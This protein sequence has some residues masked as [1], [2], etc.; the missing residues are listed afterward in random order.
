MANQ[1]LVYLTDSDAEKFILFQKYYDKFLMFLK[2]YDKFVLLLEKK[3]FEQIAAVI[4]VHF[5][6]QGEIV[7]INRSDL[8][9]QKGVNFINTN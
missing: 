5:D 3:F 1:T 7:N 9:Y 2:Y 8:L 6:K 4:S